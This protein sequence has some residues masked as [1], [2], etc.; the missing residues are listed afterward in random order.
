[1][2]NKHLTKSKKKGKEEEEKRLVI[3]GTY[4]NIIQ[5]I[6]HFERLQTHYRIISSTMLLATFP[7]IG[8]I[9]SSQV[10]LLPI[11]ISIPTLWRRRSSGADFASFRAAPTATSARFL[12]SHFVE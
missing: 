11:D 1:M 12:I 4:T 10:K 5:S 9:L 2:S 3:Y 7:A 8:F 6:K